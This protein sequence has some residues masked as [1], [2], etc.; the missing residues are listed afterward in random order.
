[1]RRKMKKGFTLIE[2]LVVVLI[3]GILTAV[4]LP[5]YQKAVEHANMVEAA[6]ILR[7]IA[8]ANQLYYMQT[9]EYAN[10]NDIEKLDVQVPGQI[11]TQILSN[12]RISTKNFIYSPTGSGL[13]YLALAQ[14]ADNGV[15]RGTQKGYYLYIS[16]TEPNRIRCSSYSQTPDLEKTLCDE[17]NQDGTL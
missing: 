13:P 16:R 14:R 17:L 6:V 2:L 15:W 12:T 4:A 8:N 5:Q 11:T 1:M 9:G 7:S 3:V 10:E